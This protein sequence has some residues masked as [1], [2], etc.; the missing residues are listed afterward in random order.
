MQPLRGILSLDTHTLCASFRMLSYETHPGHPSAAKDGRVHTRSEATRHLYLEGICQST[1]WQQPRHERSG[2]PIPSTA[3]DGDTEEE[4]RDSGPTTE[5]SGGKL[6]VSRPTGVPTCGPLPGPHFYSYPY[7]IHR[8]HTM[9]SD[10]FHL[11]ITGTKSH[12][13]KNRRRP[14]SHTL[15]QEK[16]HK[17]GRRHH[18]LRTRYWNTNTEDVEVQSL[19]LLTSGSA[20]EVRRKSRELDTWP[21]SLPARTLY[22]GSTRQPPPTEPQQR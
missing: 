21:I 1:D 6:S 18:T 11:R 13:A 16:I 12:L 8:R 17:A 19:T 20:T 9:L 5:P 22:L 7:T 4:G 2:G 10:P 14:P 15:S 3:R